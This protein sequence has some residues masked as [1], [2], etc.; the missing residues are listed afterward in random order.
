MDD[1][2]AEAF[3][4]LQRPHRF[5]R[6]DRQVPGRPTALGQDHEGTVQGQEPPVPGCSGSIPRPAGCTLTAQQPEN[7][8]VRV[9]FQALAAVLGGTQSLHT[10][11]MD[12]ALA[13]P[14][15][16]GRPDRPADPADHRSRIG[17][18]RH[19]R[20]A[21][22]LL[23]CGAL[24]EQ[25][26]TGRG[27]HPQDRRDG[28]GGPAIEKGFIQREIQD[29]AYRISGR[30]RSRNRWLWDS[31]VSR[32]RSQSPNNLLRVDPTVRLSQIEKMKRLKAERDGAAVEK[33]LGRAQTRRPGRA[34]P[35]APIL[36]AVKA[37]ATL[38]EICDVLRGVFGE[39]QQVNTLG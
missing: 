30:S 25:I 23:L 27:I 32:S 14:S 24:T 10:N 7:N 11:S 20:S 28:R 5:P 34:Q 17:G 3:L 15:G 13:L 19:R 39:Y 22:R 12:E 35:H 36:Q 33:A 6:R 29:S 9:A 26:E 37:Y 38:G 16:G 1:F 8:V 2:R 18:H 4:F 21:G 31:I